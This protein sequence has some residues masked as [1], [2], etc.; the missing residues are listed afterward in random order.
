MDPNLIFHFRVRA[1][2]HKPFRLIGVC[3]CALCALSA[4]AALAAVVLE[5]FID[6][7]DGGDAKLETAYTMYIAP[8]ISH[9]AVVT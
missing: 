6:G 3:F 4:L 1:M 5:M 9:G 8:D 7:D 2:V